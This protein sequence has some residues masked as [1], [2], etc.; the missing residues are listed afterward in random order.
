MLEII[1]G[2]F[3]WGIIIGLLLSFFGAWMLARFT[4]ELSHKKLKQNVVKF[5]IDIIR[6]LRS[7]INDMD[8]N[9]DRSEAIHHDFLGLIDVEIGIYARNREHLVHLSAPTRDKVRSFMNDCAIKR[10]NI[11]ANL[12]DFYP[13]IN[14]AKAARSAGREVKAN[15]LEGQALILLTSAQTA[16]D[17][18][19]R[20]ASDGSELLNDLAKE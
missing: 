12:E 13:L 14:R 4:V 15:E 5:L 18:L 11:V 6:N 3:F 7:T 20:L 9:R 19:V 10:A 8:A 2:Q 16:A 17:K 1:Q